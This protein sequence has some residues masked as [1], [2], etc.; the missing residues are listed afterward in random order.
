[1]FERFSNLYKNKDDSSFLELIKWFFSKK[2]HKESWNKKIFVDD[3]LIPEPY[4]SSLHEVQIIY[5]GHTTFLIQTKNFN[6]LTDPIWLERASPFDFLGPKRIQKPGIKIKNLPKIDLILISH[7]HYD[8]LCIKTLDTLNKIHKPKI[9]M[10][11]KN[12]QIIERHIKNVDIT[13]LDWSQSIDINDKDIKIHLEPAQ[14]WSS[15]FFFDKNIS[16]WGTFIVE[17]PTYKICFIG[18]SGYHPELFKDIAKKHKDILVSLIPI[19][20]SKPRK[21]M[22]YVHM[23]QEEAVLTHLDLNSK[24]SIASHFD[25]FP[26]ADDKFNEPVI[27]LNKS[28]KKFNIDEKIFIAPKVGGLYKFFKKI[29]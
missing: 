5:I 10:P 8:H 22:K 4:S 23:N 16:L 9:I 14:H 15:R 29:D 27:E 6:I 21:L 20:A 24:Y 2:N 25:V 3:S 26:L 28:L 17:T 1:M 19:G 12:R 7:N 13:E 11:L 18:D